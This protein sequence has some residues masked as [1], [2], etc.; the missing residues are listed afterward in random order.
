LGKEPE[1]DMASEEQEK[2]QQLWASRIEQWQASGLSMSRWCREQQVS[3]V[4][5][6]YWRK[7]SQ[8]KEGGFIELRDSEVTEAG[9]SIELGAVRV[10]LNRR[11]DSAALK[12]VL[13]ILRG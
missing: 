1:G 8:P 12:Q 6:S 10:V 2:K 11:F 7:K 5:L 4:Q 13:Q 9:I 3:L